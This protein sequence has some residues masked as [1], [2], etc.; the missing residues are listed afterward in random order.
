MTFFHR[1]LQLTYYAIWYYNLLLPFWIVLK[2]KAL[3]LFICSINSFLFSIV[4]L[5]T[6]VIL[7]CNIV[8]RHETILSLL[9]CI[10]ALVQ[11]F[12]KRKMTLDCGVVGSVNPILKQIWT[13]TLRVVGI[14]HLTDS[15]F[16]LLTT[17]LQVI[18][19]LFELYLDHS[20]WFES[21]Y[22]INRCLN[23]RYVFPV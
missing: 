23:Y 14:K 7:S 5:E 22:K 18:T 1:S 4:L 20:S 15:G 9:R 19:L 3:S 21:F 6:E 17:L 13:S 12:S 8:L 11:C 2:T 16:S 10:E